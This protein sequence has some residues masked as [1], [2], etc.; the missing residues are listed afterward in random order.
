MNS[1]VNVC[2]NCGTELIPQARFCRICGTKLAT[3]V[4]ATSSSPITPSIEGKDA[5][6][7]D[8]TIFNTLYARKRVKEIEK[9]IKKIL[10]EVEMLVNKSKAGL[11]DKQEAKREID[12]AKQKVLKLTQEKKEWENLA[13][14]KLEVEKLH[15]SFS[16][17]SDK[18]RKLNDMKHAGTIKHPEVHAEMVRKYQQELA[19]IRVELDR[20]LQSLQLWMALLR[21]ELT[22]QEKEIEKLKIQV[23][24]KEISKSD[25]DKKE[26][27]ILEKNKKKRFVLQSLREIYEE[28]KS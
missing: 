19:T 16:D 26:K 10:Q 6:K 13:K 18:L 23:E 22:Q 3:T 17:V 25:A 15:E 12:S 11:M 20:H 24:L 21:D 2:P 1:T 4:M 5:P 9:E 27:E 14:N 28:I 7:I 8:E